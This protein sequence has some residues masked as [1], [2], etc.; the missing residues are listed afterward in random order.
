M[1]MINLNHLLLILM[2]PASI[3]QIDDPTHFK[4]TVG[5]LLPESSGQLPVIQLELGLDQTPSD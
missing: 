1:A 5:H 2:K 3:H 4:I